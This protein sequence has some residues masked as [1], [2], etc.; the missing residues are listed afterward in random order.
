MN[1]TNGT[2]GLTVLD[3]AHEGRVLAGRPL[4]FLIGRGRGCHLRPAGD[5]VGTL[6]CVVEDRE[7]RPVVRDLGSAGGTFVNGERLTGACHLIDGDELRVGPLRLLV[8]VEGR[9][10]LAP[11]Y[12]ADDAPAGLIP[13]CAPP[14]PGPF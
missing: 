11:E 2:W 14:G 8:T 6:H 4:P 7:G 9:P 3:G 12:D 5:G 1:T 13:G 10:D